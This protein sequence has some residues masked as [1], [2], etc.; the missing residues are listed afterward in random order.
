[1]TREDGN[2]R[3][4]AKAHIRYTANDFVLY[5]F[6]LSLVAAMFVFAFSE[7]FSR[8]FSAVA[9]GYLLYIFVRKHGAKIDPAAFGAIARGIACYPIYLLKSFRS[10]GARVLQ[11]ICI[12]SLAIGLEYLLAP[13]LEGSVWLKSLPWLY[14]VWVPFGF[15]TAY[16]VIILMAHL[17]KSK[18]VVAVLKSSP[19][20]KSIVG[21]S[22]TNHIVHA[23]VTGLIV[24]LCML[25][26]VVVFL[27]LFPP[28][29]LREVLLF[30]GYIFWCL[31][32]GCIKHFLPSCRFTD[33]QTY[34]RL[35]YFRLF[36]DN[37]RWDHASRF[38]FTVFHGHHHDALPSSLAAAAGG[39]GFLEST[40][41]VIAWLDFLDSVIICQMYWIVTV[42]FDMLSHQ[43]IPGV[44]PYSKWTINS[45]SHHV[46]H[47]FGSLLPLGTFLY[48]PHDG[49]DDLNQGYKRNNR[50]TEWFLDTAAVYE[51]LD[52]NTQTRFLSTDYSRLKN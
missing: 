4:R 45:G 50:C 14:F 38:Y 3:H 21:V 33:G 13:A 12:F 27:S 23:F 15:L 48:L 6:S 32:T 52:S 25:V 29:I 43:Y 7:P 51:G 24:H 35:Q 8:I 5:L 30:G 19:I 26:P 18:H 2:L 1:M 16:R 41:R 34:R 42:F 49:T 31:C 22:I 40:N 37:H 44:F 20:R 39:V 28:S 36:H 11:V 10:V 46:A 47:H 17:R 9:L